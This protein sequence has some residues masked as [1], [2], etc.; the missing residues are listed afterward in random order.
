MIAKALYKYGYV[1][2]YLKYSDEEK[3]ICSSILH[4]VYMR[5]LIYSSY[6]K[7]AKADIYWRCRR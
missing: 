2:N 7:Y 4:I 1:C 3:Y 6:A 5:F